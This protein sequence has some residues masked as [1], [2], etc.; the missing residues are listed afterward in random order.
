MADAWLYVYTVG[1]AIALHWRWT[2]GA[3]QGVPANVIWTPS[4]PEEAGAR[5]PVGPSSFWRWV[6]VPAQELPLMKTSDLFH[7]RFEELEVK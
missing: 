1:Y 6:E 4:K 5:D 7:D 3:F 2:P